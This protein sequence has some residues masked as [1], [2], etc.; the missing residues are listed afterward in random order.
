[1]IS[2]NEKILLSI[3]AMYFIAGTLS[4]VFVNVYLYAF[5]GSLYAMTAYAIVRFGMFPIGFVLGGTLSKKLNLSRVLSTGL[6]IIVTALAFLLGFNRY[7]EQTPT[8]IYSLG[9]IFGIGEGLYWFSI[10]ALNLTAST[11]ESRGKFVMTQGILNS[12]ATVIAPFVATQI[13]AFSSS[14]TLGYIRIF[15]VVIVLQSL[16]AFLSTRVNLA[17]IEMNIVYK[18]KFNFKQDAQWRYIMFNHFFLGIRDSL[19]LVLTGL[20]VYNAT[21]GSGSAYGNLL[22]VFA[23]INVA[24]N[25][26]ASRI[27]KRNNRMISYV[28]A[29]FILF[30]STMILVLSPNLMGAIYF[31]VTNAL[32]VP[33]YV[34]PFMIISMNA[35]SDYIAKENIYARLIIKEFSLNGGRVLGMLVILLF[36][37]LFS[38]SYSMI[39]GVTFSSSFTIILA[40]YANAYHKKRDAL[41]HSGLS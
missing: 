12:S 39:F 38:E 29:S 11:K 10:S 1:M 5:T 18:D 41:K 25:F 15:Q 14:D 30:S 3:G 7:F 32:A 9:I 20:L 2:I 22:T 31:G 6:L 35:L 34:N 23:L 16:A 28:L 33:F 24:S 21:G 26:V 4:A 27:I 37:R 17:K 8:L 19:T 13:V 36:S 40:L